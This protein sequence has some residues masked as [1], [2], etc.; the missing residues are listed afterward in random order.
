MNNALAYTD[1][2]KRYR[3]IHEKGIKEKSYLCLFHAPSFTPL[4]KN[5]AS[6]HERNSES[7]KIGVS[8]LGKADAYSAA[9]LAPAA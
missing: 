5:A 3:T 6:L 7:M 2:L 4:C 1:S 9:C 8:G